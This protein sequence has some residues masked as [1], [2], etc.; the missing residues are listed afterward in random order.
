[1][2]APGIAWWNRLPESERRDW[3]RCVGTGRVADAWQLRCELVA[4]IHGKPANK[5]T[6]TTFG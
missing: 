5:A 4:G 6:S 3:L 2:S 1:V